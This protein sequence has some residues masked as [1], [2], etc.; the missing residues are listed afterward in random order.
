MRTVRQAEFIGKVQDVLLRVVASPDNSEE[1]SQLSV[2][3]F[4]FMSSAAALCG[5]RQLADYVD[6]SMAFVL[7]M[8]PSTGH[9]G[10][11]EYLAALSDENTRKL[12]RFIDSYASRRLCH[13]NES[14]DLVCYCDEG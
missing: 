9:S 5:C 2:D 14:L 6:E 13:L 12:A 3:P 10:P 1:H 11:S 4:S 8:S 7:E